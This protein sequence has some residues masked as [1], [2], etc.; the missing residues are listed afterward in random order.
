MAFRCAD[1]H[2]NGDKGCFFLWIIYEDSGAKVSRVFERKLEVIR[3]LS[4]C[5]SLG[6][7]PEQRAIFESHL[8]GKAVGQS[9]T[10]RA[11]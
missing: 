2:S 3:F 4:A 1:A 7:Y 10:L 8:V 11:E 9:A 6:Y 5:P